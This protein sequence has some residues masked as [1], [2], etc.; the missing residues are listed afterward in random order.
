VAIILVIDDDS[1]ARRH[2][3]RAVISI[4]Y[5]T[6]YS[7]GGL[8]VLEVVYD[9]NPDL[10]L[11]DL[12][13]SHCDGVDTLGLLLGNSLTEPVPLVMIAA[14]FDRG[15]VLTGMSAGA[16]D[17]IEKPVSE[18]DLGFVLNRY[19]LGRDLGI[20]GHRISS[21]RREPAYLANSTRAA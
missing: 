11:L 1:V 4:G 17:Y 14:I 21:A 19:L 13:T 18:D 10:I 2:F 16:V 20:Q 6:V 7:T 5:E 12:T 9:Q 3:S 8:P 15:R